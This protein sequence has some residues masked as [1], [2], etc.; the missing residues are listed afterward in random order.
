MKQELTHQ[1]KGQLL[2]LL[3][4]RLP[5]LGDYPYPHNPNAQTHQPCPLHGKQET[6]PNWLP[7]YRLEHLEQHWHI[8]FP[9]TG[10][11]Q[12]ELAQ[13]EQEP[14]AEPK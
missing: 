6:V 7:F 11:E 3:L 14:P 8:L 1:H 9:L 10:H 12:K 13:K 5:L 2:L 4:P